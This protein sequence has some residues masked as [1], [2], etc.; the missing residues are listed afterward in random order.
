MTPDPAAALAFTA[1]AEQ[2]ASIDQLNDAASR[3][4]AD[5]GVS[6]FAANLITSPGRL[7][8]PGILFGRDWERW[9]TRYNRRGYAAVDPALTMLREMTTPFTWSEAQA[10][11]GSADGAEVIRDCLDFTG[12]A[13][14][15]VVPVRGRD[16]VVFTAAF[17]G[18]EL[19]TDPAVRPMLQLIG[20]YYVTRGCDLKFDIR[21]NPACPL[22]S[23]QIECLRWVF[24][25]KTEI[26]IA[27]ILGISS[28]TVHTHIKAAMRALG[29]TNRHLASRYAWR[30]GWFDYP[31]QVISSAF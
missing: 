8:R 25:G 30:S 10:R 16:G 4:L 22:T 12:C 26:E 2:I 6:C 15:L 31:E 3:V 18:R 19:V 7:S 21:L 5:F 24:E 1:R 17:C 11:F 27:V 14:G 13:E 29:L 9:S 23:R 28:N 20:Y